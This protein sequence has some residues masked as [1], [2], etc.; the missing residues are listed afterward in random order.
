[1]RRGKIRGKGVRWVWRLA[2]PLHGEDEGELK[3]VT[4]RGRFERFG[5]HEWSGSN[6]GEEIDGENG[7]REGGSYQSRRT[8]LLSNP[9]SY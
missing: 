5:V 4:E 1:M 6:A 2:S 9:A 7:M 8:I 3:M